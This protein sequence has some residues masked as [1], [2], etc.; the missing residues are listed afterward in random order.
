MFGSLSLPLAVVDLLVVVFA[1]VTLLGDAW[2]LLIG[3][4]VCYWVGPRLDDSAR[5]AA[6]TAV[7]FA[8]LALAAVLAIKSFTAIPRPTAV[9]TNPAE[10]PALV[11]PFVAGEIDSG[12]FSFPSG[13]ATGSTAVYGALGILLAVGRRHRRYLLAGTLIVLI[14]L[15]RVV[16]RVHYVR[17]VLA[18]MVL[19]GVLLLVGLRLAR[20]DNRLRPDHLH[21]AYL[22]PDRVFLL[23]AVAA[24][25]GLGVALWAGHPD[26]IR[27]G[28][29]GVG[30]AAGGLF[31]WRRL[32]DRLLAAPSVSPGWAAAGLLIA[33]GLWIAAYLGVFSLVGA[34]LASAAGVTI[35]LAL[36]LLEQRL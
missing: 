15:S 2:F 31:T 11:G 12:G 16:L 14:S 19:G 5:P 32:G 8:T 33:G 28:A 1:F 9:P 29:I 23:A 22:R 35:V 3:L 24:I 18:G 20:G 17:D 4:S 10:L 30:T 21:S 7:G 13:H 26:E 25:V 27:Q 6:A 34:G 36:P